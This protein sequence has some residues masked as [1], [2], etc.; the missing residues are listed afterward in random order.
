MPERLAHST[1]YLLGWPP[2][3]RSAALDE[4]L[5]ALPPDLRDEVMGMEV[6][7][8][9]LRLG[10]ILGLRFTGVTLVEDAVPQ[11]IAHLAEQA[12]RYTS[13]QAV[14]E[15]PSPTTFDFVVPPL[16]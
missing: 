5:D 9:L 6:G 11:V 15:L 14:V 3:G 13:D 2:G 16:L 12:G 10:E 8:A 1:S 7:A 4:L